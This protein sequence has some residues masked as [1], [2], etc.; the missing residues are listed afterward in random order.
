MFFFRKVAN[1]LGVAA[2]KVATS[3]EGCHMRAV[4]HSLS[5]LAGNW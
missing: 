3:H 5:S 1:G 2:A 4:S